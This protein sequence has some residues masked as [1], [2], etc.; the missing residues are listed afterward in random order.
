MCVWQGRGEEVLH[1]LPTRTFLAIFI[2]IFSTRTLCM[3]GKLA[4][5][6]TLSYAPAPHNTFSVAS[7]RGMRKVFDRGH[8][9]F[10]TS[11]L[12]LHLS[13]KPCILL[14]YYREYPLHP[15]EKSSAF[16]LWKETLSLFSWALSRTFFFQKHFSSFVYIFSNHLIN[17]IIAY[18][19]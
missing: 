3:W 11:F 12:P 14:T 13:L 8:Y 1:F 9:S 15:P 4:S 2:N 19:E 6:L 16:W 18:W 17:F 5:F 7:L 10:L